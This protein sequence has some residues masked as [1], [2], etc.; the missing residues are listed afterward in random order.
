MPRM[1]KMQMTFFISVIDEKLRLPLSPPKEWIGGGGTPSENGRISETYYTVSKV[2]MC[3]Q[4][5][6]FNH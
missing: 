2:V 4:F 5:A 6:V 1:K 3:K